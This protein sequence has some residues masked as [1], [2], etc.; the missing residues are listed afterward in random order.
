MSTSKTHRRRPPSWL[1]VA[2]AVGAV[3]AGGGGIGSRF[4]GPA[5]EL[6]A[7]SAPTSTPTSTP[8]QRPAGSSHHRSLKE[9]PVHEVRTA[10]PVPMDATA[11]F[12][13]GLTLRLV[14]TDA[15][16]GKAHGPGELA[17]PAVRF[18][19]RA[20]NHTSRSI[21]LDGTV[22]AVD[23]GSARTPAIP[24]SSGGRPFHGHL[25]GGRT[26]TGSYVDLIPPARRGSVRIV[27]TYD[28][29]APAVVIRGDAR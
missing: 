16:Q 7:S 23:Y 3:A 29:S 10:A 21:P 1:L 20:T 6:A 22:V 2:L 12:G 17:G 9:V 26:A 13:T 27:V 25:A 4:V 24:L 14:R 18:V 11:D 8:A 28:G 15:V 19:L 5:T